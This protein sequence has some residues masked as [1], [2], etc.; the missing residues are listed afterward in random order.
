MMF[1]NEAQERW[2][3]NPNATYSARGEAALI[4]ACWHEWRNW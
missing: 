2:G 4:G 1:G 3:S